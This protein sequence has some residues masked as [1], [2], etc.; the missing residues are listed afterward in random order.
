MCIRD[1]S[2][3][4]DIVELTQS[5]VPPLE[6]PF[7][8]RHSNSEDRNHRD[9]RHLETLVCDRQRLNE[10][11]NERG[12]CDRIQGRVSPIQ[13]PTHYK[14]TRHNRS[15]DNW[16]LPANEQRICGDRDKSK[17]QPLSSSSG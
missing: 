2:V 9:K 6:Y 14:D 13:R 7:D 11:K 8:C 4:V 12:Q 10:K 5:Q 1:R 17:N 3:P 16:H 15:S